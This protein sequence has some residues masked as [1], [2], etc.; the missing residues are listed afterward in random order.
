LDLRQK[1]TDLFDRL[2]GESLP[3]RYPSVA[4]EITPARVTGVRLAHDRKTGKRRIAAVESRDLFE[5]AIEVSLMKPNIQQP[6]AV[7]LVV[8]Q[9]LH[10]L[11]PEDHR[12]SLLLPDDVARVALLGFAALPKTRR[13]LL[14]LVRFRMSKSLPFKP[15]E[16]AVDLMILEGSAHH[17]GAS[18][19]SV[20]AS[21]VHR[22]VLEQYE[23]LC[24]ACGYW[25]GLVSLSTFELFNLFRPLFARKKA[26]DRDSLVLNVTGE[27]LSVVIL[28]DTDVI[29][30]RCKPHLAVAGGDTLADVRRELYTS[31]AFYQEKLLGRGIGRVFLR[32]A[33]LPLAP[34]REAAGAETGGEVEILDP[35][36]VVPQNGGPPVSAEQAALLAPVIGAVA[37]RMT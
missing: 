35:L 5:G 31:L 20:L 19:A 16:A 14:D 11:A 30:Y 2:G 21:F 12:V 8:E 23:S 33:D 6:E 1:F 29:F 13:E 24:A 15:E 27:Y 4:M 36:L 26:V 28:R 37:G 10:A 7:R 32:C 3:P 9:V 34:I 18:T 25:P 22:G 17:P